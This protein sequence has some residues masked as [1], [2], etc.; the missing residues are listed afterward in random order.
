METI[1]LNKVLE[2]LW[3]ARTLLNEGKETTGKNIAK[4]YLGSAIEEIKEELK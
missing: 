4:C 1:L 2:Q 3:H